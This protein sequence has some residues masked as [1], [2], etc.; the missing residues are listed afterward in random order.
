MKKYIFILISLCISILSAWSVWEG[1][2][3]AGAATDFQED[4]MFV[5]SSLF[6]KYTLIEIVNLEND[7]KARAIVLEGKEVP[8]CR[9]FKGAIWR[10]Y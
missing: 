2:G 8:G 3:I 5:K 4:G 1:N 7:I 6:P 10:C 9:G